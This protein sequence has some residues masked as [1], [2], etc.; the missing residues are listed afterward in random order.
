MLTGRLLA[1]VRQSLGGGGETVDAERL[2]ANGFLTQLVT[3][4]LRRGGS[5]PRTVTRQQL[6]QDGAQLRR[7]A[8][9]RGSKPRCP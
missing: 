2:S 6:I 9:Q 7:V 3:E 5:D 4:H 8:K 1:R